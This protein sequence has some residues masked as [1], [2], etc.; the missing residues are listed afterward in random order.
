MG[1]HERKRDPGRT[2]LAV[3]LFVIALGLAG[4]SAFLGW[5]NSRERALRQQAERE[6]S[7][8]IGTLQGRLDEANDSLSAA[9]DT[10]GE[11]RRQL[12]DDPF[13]PGHPDYEDLYPDFYAP[14]PLDASQTPDHVMYLT[15][16]DGP[17]GRTDEILPI[18]EQEGI[19]A[20]FFEVGAYLDGNQANI[21]RAKR[22]VEQGH[23][24]AMHSYSH[25]YGTIYTSVEAFLDD[26]YKVFVIMRDQVGYTPTMF[27]FPG[28]S[29]NAY[30]YGVEQDIISE[31]LRRGFVPYDWNVSAQDATS[32][33]LP[34]ETI[35]D[36][37]MSSAAGK[38]YGVVLMHDSSARTTTVEALPEMIR[39]LREQ[40][41]TFAALT[42]EVKPILFNYRNNR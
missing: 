12:E 20:T 3:A 16:D 7:Q 24:L 34:V 40:G 25:R 17:S 39:R 6:A 11:L 30:N 8:T 28:G 29:T 14:Q 1:R 15:F 10:I 37:V 13:V 26:M 27:R 4:L 32:R 22:I 38:K 18:L 5:Q 35:L 31:M 23:T 9:N 21:D 41:Y 42:P 19:K 33:P 36:N 2:A